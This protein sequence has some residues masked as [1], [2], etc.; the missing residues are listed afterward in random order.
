MARANGIGKRFLLKRFILWGI[1]PLLLFGATGCNERLKR[2]ESNQVVL[3]EKIDYNARQA[4]LLSQRMEMSQALLKARVERVQ[5]GNNVALAETRATRYEQ[6]K[7]REETRA[8]GQKWYAGITRVEGHQRQLQNSVNGVAGTTDVIDEGL[9]TTQKNQMGLSGLIKAHHKYAQEVGRDIEG[10]EAEQKSMNN[11]MQQGNRTVNLA[12]KTVG[13]KQNRLQK[14]LVNVESIAVATHKET[15]AI[16]E[17][18]SE[19]DVQQGQRHD[20]V[21]QA[22]AGLESFQ[23]ATQDTIASQTGMI[24]DQQSKLKQGLVKEGTY[25]RQDLALL[26]QNQGQLQTT[27]NQVELTA[28]AIKNNNQE[29]V[30]TTHDVHEQ[31][32]QIQREL[33]Q[34]AIHFREGLAQ[35]EKTQG[36]LQENVAGVQ[37]TANHI[38]DRSDENG[39]AIEGVRNGQK[40]I[41]KGVA[42]LDKTQI[43]LQKSVNRV[44]A[45][46]TAIEGKTDNNA[47]SL[48]DIY[49]QQAPIHKELTRLDT[50]QDQLQYNVG[51]VQTTVDAVKM[52]AESNA[53]IAR[54]IQ[55][56]QERFQENVASEEA[57]TRQVLTGVRKDQAQVNRSVNTMQVTSNTVISNTATLMEQ[58][59]ALQRV[60]HENQSE[61]VDVLGQVTA[62][63]SLLSQQ[64]SK[65]GDSVT[66]V[67]A[68]TKAIADDTKNLKQGQS[69]LETKVQNGQAN[70]VQKATQINASHSSLNQTIRDGK[71]DLVVQLEA[72][73]ENQ[74]K[75]AQAMAGNQQAAQ[76]Q[77]KDI[78]QRADALENGLGHDHENI[79]SLQTNLIAQ[80]TEL[81]RVMQAL[82]VQGGGQITQLSVDMKAFK[83]TLLQ[84]KATQSALAKRFNQVDVNQTKRNKECLSLLEKLQ[85]QTHHGLDDPSVEAESEEVDVVK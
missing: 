40:P 52:Q 72:I 12:V 47:K 61:L 30:K 5:E 69:V 58:Q 66:G 51:R 76:S 49:T 70:M 81:T 73:R 37:A 54:D 78:S 11:A 4:G 14:T 80:I 31:Q 34:E 84:I 75:L 29:N 43:Q 27:L 44:Q 48:H 79:S 60:S 6:E 68:T 50:K 24:R 32:N 85:K 25:I 28:N 21:I 19:S 17:R 38:K 83:G 63:Q 22:M 67:A 9:K 23:K 65:L 13:K 56:Q 7:L 33:A 55:F 41:Q 2:M 64:Q 36:Q 20:V 26:K 35:L 18:Q 45:T 15:E 16:A 42:Q 3:E 1:L 46:A 74:S 8:F 71:N 77:T 10:I 53:R 39:Q 59:A 57:E 62:K 82:Q